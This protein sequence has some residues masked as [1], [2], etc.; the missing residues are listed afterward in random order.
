M[1]GEAF[2]TGAEP[3]VPSE[4]G[5]PSGGAG[6]TPAMKLQILST[7]HWNLLAT[8][9]MTWNE[10]FSR[11]SIFLSVLSGATVALALVAQATAFG[12][13]FLVFALVILPVV[14]FIGLTTYAR[15]LEVNAEDILWVAGM[16]RIRNA[17]LQLAPDLEPYFITGHHDDVRGIELTFGLQQPANPILHAFITIPGMVAA[18]D[19]VLAGVL[20]ALIVMQVGMDLPL[21]VGVGAAAVVALVAALNLVQRRAMIGMAHPALGRFPSPPEQGD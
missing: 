18:V 21:A 14:L 8:R 19:G 1:T 16:N 10:A 20:A 3:P 9:S 6:A 15:L 4:A 5:G 13:A 2:R 12:S 11:T 7:E 17:Y